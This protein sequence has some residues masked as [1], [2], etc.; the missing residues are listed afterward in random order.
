MTETPVPTSLVKRS[1]IPAWVQA[2]IAVLGSGSVILALV[3]LGLTNAS[4]QSQITA[5][6]QS[7]TAA[8]DQ[9]V[10]LGAKPV[11]PEPEKITGQPGVAG[12]VGPAGKDGIS[13]LSVSCSSSG[14]F[15]VVYSTGRT[16]TGVG[17]CIAKDGAS[18]ANGT[19]G[20]PGA[21]GATGP[22]GADGQPPLS[23]TY[24][25]PLGFTYS[26]NRASPFDS[27]Q[28]TYTCARS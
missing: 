20:S 3:V 22:S 11:A 12:P 4:L 5:L 27:S 13:V 10:Q 9:V 21:T 15:T 24:T 17:D 23:W 1:H 14:T 8:N 16:Q 19:N 26:C 28:P 6:S 18:G 25:D 7:L 2:L